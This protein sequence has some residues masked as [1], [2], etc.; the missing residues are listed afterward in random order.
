MLQSIKDISNADPDVNNEDKLITLR[1]H[2]L[3]LS[4]A[5]GQIEK[6]KDKT[7]ESSQT[8]RTETSVIE[9]LELWQQVFRETFQQYHRLST[10]LVKNEDSAAALKLWQEYLVHVQQFLAGTIPDDYHSLSEHQHLCQLHQNLLTTQQNVLKPL[11]TKEGGTV[12]MSVMEQFNSLTN[13]H[14]ETLS[15][16]ME[17]HSEV[18]NRLNAWDK[19]RQDQNKLLAWLKDMEKERERLQLRYIHMRRVPKV[20]SRISNLLSKLPQG[21]EKA[22]QLQKQQNHLLQFCDE[23]LATSIRMEHVAITQRI[24]NLQ[25]GLETWRKFL[26]RIQELIKSYEDG[27]QVVQQMFE[28]VQE[29]IT[30]NAADIPTTHSGISGRLENLQRA[31]TRL[32]GLTKDLEQLGITQEQLKECVSPSDMKTV[33]QRMWL[34]W[35]QQSD[36]DHQLAILCHQL[37]EKL[38]VRSMF[39]ARQ[40]RFIAWTKELEKRFEQDDVL[41]TADIKD[42][43]EILQKL[44]TELEAELSLKEREYRWLV[45]TGKELADSCGDEYSDV[46]AKQNIQTRTSE[47]EERWQY[48]QNLGKTRSDKINGMIQTMTTLE[49]R[50]AEIRAWLTQIEAQLSKPVLFK[51]ATKPTIDEQLQE[52][53]KLKKSIEKESGNIGEV[54]NL[55]ELLLSDADLW[56]TYFTTENITTAVQNL[57][58]RWKNVCGVSAERKRKITFAWKLLQEVLKLSGEHERWLQEQEDTLAKLESPQKHSKDQIKERISA[59]EN[60]LNEIEVHGPEFEI[61]EHT[62][63]K[64]AKTSSLDPENIQELTT[65]AKDVILRWHTLKPR[66]IDALQK[67]KHELSLIEDFENAH[68]DAVMNLTKVD[69]QLTELQ[70]LTE[71]ETPEKRLGQ[72]ENVERVL[73]AQNPTLENADKLGLLILKKSDKQEAVHIQQ[74][75]DEYQLLWKDIQGRIITLKSDLQEQIKLQSGKLREVDESVQ[76]ETL[77]FEE[78]AAVQVN[79]LHPK[80][81][82]MT[83][84]SA[85][86]AYLVELSTAL[87]ELKSN[88]DR[89]EDMVTKEIPQQG[90]PELHTSAKKIAKLSGSCQSNVELVQ[91]LHDLLVNE[92]NASAEEVKGEEVEGLVKKFEALLGRAKSKEQKIRELRWVVVVIGLIVLVMHA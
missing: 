60:E 49:Q 54:L 31:R 21:E 44:E 30:A 25:A 82:R 10:R 68:G 67:F 40:S 35:H 17:R 79:T 32:A 55:C 83:S 7:L 34:L 27:V 38:G 8:T 15:R 66:A 29:I 65:K 90:S 86:D 53:D 74:M 52:H 19:Y 12:E 63:S 61:L 69:A 51:D 91:H 6:I 9:I 13:L 89:L 57:E 59:L 64:L 23:A 14:N 2:L 73:T 16:I 43:E 78:D 18:Q 20:L 33:N 81:Q 47:V 26:E 62:Y 56:K 77:K 76:V 58:K 70:H 88:L 46:V 28:N 72:L 87:Q 85:K 3:S 71:A 11:D 4:K 84:I 1:D 41:S 5:E 37:E 48:L 39:E 80:L 92:C 36:L 50:I 75:I 24:S 45:N 22:A 42:P